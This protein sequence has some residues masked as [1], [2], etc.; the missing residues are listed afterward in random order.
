MKGYWVTFVATCTAVGAL[1]VLVT[2]PVASAQPAS[3]QTPSS[4]TY[5][6]SPYEKEAIDLTLKRLHGEIDRSPEGK[7]VEAIDIVTLE[8]IEPRDPLPGFLNVFHVVSK[9]STIEREVVLKKGSPYVQ[10][11]ADETARNLRSLPQLSVVICLPLRGSTPERVRLLVITK[12]IWSLRQNSDIRLSSNGLELLALQPSEINL[13]GLHHTATLRFL[14]DPASYTLGAQYTIPRISPYHLRISALGNV[15]VNRDN[16]RPEGSS[17]G[18]SIG[19]G[20]VT[21]QTR[22]R[23]RISTTWLNEM[24]RRFVNAKI[25]T[26]DWDQTEE[27]ERIAFAYRSLEITHRTAVT[28][29]WGWHMKDDV[30]FGLEFRHR[31]YTVPAD[32]SVSEQAIE[33]F[34]KTYVPVS[35]TRLSPFV[36]YDTYT[37]DFLRVLDFETLGLQEDFRLGHYGILKLYPAVRGAGSS[38]TLMGIYSATQY[39]FATGDGLI[40]AGLE[41]HSEVQPDRVSDASFEAKWRAITPRLGFG[42]LLVDA[43]IVRRYRN[44][45]NQTTMIGG[46]NRLRGYPSN[47]LV[48]QDIAVNNLE[49]RTQPLELLKFQLGAAAFYDVAAMGHAGQ[50]TELHQSVGVGLRTLFPQFDRIVFRLDVGFPIAKESLAPGVSRV[51]FYASVAQAFPMPSISAP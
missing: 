49:F 34:K 39:T 37:T 30:T 11:Q 8:V 31:T 7:I 43:T 3:S 41:A 10:V 4:T 12:D 42:R 33:Q 16:G 29:S 40:R 26:F 15:I 48:G 19:S 22:W 25:A 46:N 17:G 44:D 32:N 35:A 5:D 21:D 23:W 13:F 1:L 6:Y 28:H 50:R 51:S 36:Q 27:V 47:F 24:T 14:L 18:L 38:R 9:R 20:I 2:S 45:S